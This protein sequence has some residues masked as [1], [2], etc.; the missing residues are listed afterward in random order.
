MQVRKG[1]LVRQK[2]ISAA[3]RKLIVKNGSE[4]L[5][6]KAIAHEIGVTDG[7]IYRHFDIKNDI[8]SFLVDDIE[9]TL[10]DD[11]KIHSTGGAVSPEALDKII[12]DHLSAIRQR[13]G[14]TFQVIAEI[15]SYG[16]Q[17]L[18]TKVCAV[19]HKYVACL[20]EILSTGVRSGVI[21][22]DTN[23]D[24]AA[25]MFFGMTQGLVN[26]WALSYYKFDLEAEFQPLWHMFLNTIAAPRPVA[27]S[28][29]TAR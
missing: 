20:K 18:N 16:D 7:A 11:F 5:T 13:K 27:V 15:V 25:R 26:L 1:T 28:S 29:D 22:P 6:I 14:V 19:I 3:V 21:N 2:E 23:L 9:A 8:L 4:H 10:L 17:E 24:A 12:A